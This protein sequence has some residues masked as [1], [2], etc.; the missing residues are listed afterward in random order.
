MPAMG[1]LTEVQTFLMSARLELMMF[2]AAMVVYYVLNMHRIPHSNSKKLKGKVK[3]TYNVE[4][5]KGSPHSATPV[6]LNFSSYEEIDAS[7]QNAVHG[8]DHVSV[9]KCWEAVKQFDRA[10]IAQFPR[11]V[12]SMQSCKKD[13]AFIIRE[14]KG[15]FAKYPNQC[16]VG[17]INNLIDSVGR[18]MDSQLLDRVVETFPSLGLEKDEKTYEALLSAQLTARNFEGVQ[19]LAAEMKEKKVTFTARALVT[20]IKTAL[21]TSNFIE[22]SQSFHQL[23]TSW[24]SGDAW[25]AT[26]SQ[27]PRHV[28]SQLVELSCKEGQLHQFVT[29][30]AGV[31][32][33]EEAVNSML[34]ECIRLRDSEL[35]R[36]VEKLARE[37]EESMSD[38]TYSLLIKAMANDS[39]HARAIIQ[40]ATMCQSKK[41]SS[42]VVLAAL[43]FCSKTADTKLADNLFGQLK[44]H[45]FNV[46]SAFIRFYLDS[47]MSEKACDV[48]EQDVQSLSNEGMVDARMERSLL[49]AALRCGRTALANK[50]LEASPSDVAKHITMI[51]KCASERNLSGAFSIFESLKQSGVDLNSVVYN[52]VLDACVQCRDLKA[53]EKWMETTR[54]AGMVDVVSY[55]T[56]IKAHLLNHNSTKARSLMDE[57]RLT[58]VQPNRVTYN[59]LLNCVIAGRGRKEEI[60]EIVR[61]MKDAGITP[62]HVT[63]SILLK[64]L[65]ARSAEADVSL[66]M[67][68]LSTMEEQM[69]EVLLSS[70]VE[71]CVRIGKPDLLASKLTSLQGSNR[72][73]VNGPHTFGSL[74]KAYG[75]AGDVE[76]VWR[77]WREFRS[78]HIKPS[79]ITI[80]CMIEAVVNNGDTDGA[81]DLLQQMQD[82]EQCRS[83]LN[84]V[85]YCSVLKGF[86]R[87]KKLD[88]V[89]AVYEE[90]GKRNIEISIVTCNTVIDACARVG[91]MGCVADLLQD[92]K[93]QGVKPNLI[94]YSTMVKG[95][96]Q[97]GD[98]TTAFAVLQRMRQE[99]NLK[100]DEIMYNSL[101]GGCA[102]HSLIDEGLRLLDEMQKE[103]VQPSN[104]TLSVL[105]K[106]MN[107]ARKLDQA[108][109]S[110]REI[111]LKYDFKPNVHVYTN[112]VQ[113]C[114]S[115]HQLSRA[116]ETLEHMVEDQVQPDSR[117][118]TL[119]IRANMTSRQHQEAVALLRGALGLTGAHH[120]LAKTSSVNIDHA[121][122]NETLNGLVDR[123]LAKTLAAPLLN[124]IKSSKYKVHIDAVTQRR[125]MSSMGEHPWSKAR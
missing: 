68:L 66:T 30:L 53:A 84:S 77:C 89:W 78:R 50:L 43:M 11:I 116:M 54:Q 70:V 106:L 12:E 23:K 15:A 92:A 75:H 57:M 123:G 17:L 80:G 24:I 120:V 79:S 56:I 125:V 86:T 101:L 60:W 61:E 36:S 44:P 107:R 64:N 47:G 14:L 28:V 111:T 46:L 49:G 21:R 31:P 104:F 51:Q 98:I 117:T 65:N 103:G 52:T 41:C 25:S 39:E 5:S 83:V 76:G 59:E 118:F 32:V 58:G 7:L 38:A 72:I 3:H 37:Q 48:F 45:P 26:P 13:N 114:I 6:K 8:G 18:H 97:S 40:E 119:L 122:V 85:I 10:P 105:V 4:E 88:R 93:K 62:N 71:A 67:D 81:Y 2:F 69:D 19:L 82:D 87:E 29:E 42:E 113:A 110:V 115:N 16:D 95:H 63:C 33:S 73:A 35:A 1:F 99:T 108:F 121:L 96:C 102:Q 22:A 27:A 112:L 91:R 9:L 109:K 20:M 74:I 34:N 55:N 90:M 124:D 94:T 100:P